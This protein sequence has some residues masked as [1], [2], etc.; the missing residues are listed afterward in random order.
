MLRDPIE[1]VR[2]D[3]VGTL[4]SLL[5]ASGEIRILLSADL[6]PHYANWRVPDHGWYFGSWM[7]PVKTVT[8]SRVTDAAKAAD[9]SRK[10]TRAL[11]EDLAPIF[12]LELSWRR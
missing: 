2:T 10:E 8:T 6:D 4:V 9:I 5:D 11:Y 3:A 12:R 7:D 1:S